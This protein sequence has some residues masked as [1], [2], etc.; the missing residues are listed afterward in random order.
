[1]I[2]SSVEIET[3]T[4]APSRPPTE[5]YV[6]ITFPHR[7]PQYDYLGG[8][9]PAAS[10][11]TTVQN[12]R[13]NRRAFPRCRNRSPDTPLL[14]SSLLLL[15]PCVCAAKT[16]CDG[17][18]KSC[19]FVPLPHDLVRMERT[20]RRPA[21]VNNETLERAARSRRKLGGASAVGPNSDRW[22]RGWLVL[23]DSGTYVK[24]TQAGADLFA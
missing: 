16:S 20:P 18:P 2:A 14:L 15:H 1:M 22:W 12:Q 7:E 5:I 4:Q 9:Q 10:A 19:L 6:A 3:A 17:K 11:S 24:F 21:C 8:R 23:H 13:V